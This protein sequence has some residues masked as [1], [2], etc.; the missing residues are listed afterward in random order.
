MKLPA[1]MAEAEA[2]DVIRHWLDDL[3]A[4]WMT[5]EAGRDR[6]RQ[7]IKELLR[8]GVIGTLKVIKA[9]RVGHADADRALRELGA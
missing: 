3:L 4:E 5:I 6:M 8:H 7:D 1:T 9:A 2:V